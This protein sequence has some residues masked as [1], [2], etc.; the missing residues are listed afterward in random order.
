MGELAASDS[1]VSDPAASDLA[2]SVARRLEVVWERITDAGGDPEQVQVVAV[3]KRYGA[4]AVDAAL[5]VGLSQIGENYAQEL[6]AKWANL[7]DGVTAQTQLHFIG[8]LQTNKVRLIT[9]WVD[10]WQS[11]DRPSLIAELARRSPGASIML[12][13][14]V[15]GSDTQGGCTPSQADDLLLRARDAGLEVVGVMAIG[16]LGPPDVVRAGFEIVQR[17]ADSHQLVQRSIGM[18]GDLEQAVAAGTTMVR[19]GTALFGAL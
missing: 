5:D 7:P 2:A 6:A 10:V 15:T 12:Q 9:P 4:W 18:S 8:R 1:A 14:N 11:V 3:T 16:P 13:L 17:F 19:I